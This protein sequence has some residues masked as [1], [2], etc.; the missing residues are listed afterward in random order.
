M[1]IICSRITVVEMSKRCF[2]VNLFTIHNSVKSEVIYQLYT[3]CF[4]TILVV[5][6]LSSKTLTRPIHSS[7]RV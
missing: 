7:E 2:G 1:N 6:K 4:E 5:K 3:Q